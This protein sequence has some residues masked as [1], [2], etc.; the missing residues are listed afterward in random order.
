VFLVVR[1]ARCWK[2]GAALHINVGWRR[3]IS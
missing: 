1:A 3:G 2:D